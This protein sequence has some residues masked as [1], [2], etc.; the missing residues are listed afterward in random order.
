MPSNAKTSNKTKKSTAEED[1][2]FMQDLIKK[3][4]SKLKKKLAK[5]AKWISLTP[6]EKVKKQILK[7]AEGEAQVPPNGS[8]VEVHYIGT[9]KSNGKK[10]DSSRDRNTPFSFTLGAGN[11]IRGWDIALASMKVGEKAL[12]EI[13]SAYAYG[14]RGAGSDIPP[15]STLNFEIELLSFK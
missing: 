9:L 12:V 4:E 6:D 5:A 11:V 7:Q 10:F 15:N 2:K 8:T 13:D 3:N 14:A 1:E